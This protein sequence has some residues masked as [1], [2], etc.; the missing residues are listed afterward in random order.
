M[1]SLAG[2]RIGAG[3]RHCIFGSC[4]VL[5]PVPYSGDTPVEKTSKV[6]LTTAPTRY[7]LPHCVNRPLKI[8]GML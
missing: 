3:Y 6:F 8:F 5:F 7:L 4:A 2:L 1:N